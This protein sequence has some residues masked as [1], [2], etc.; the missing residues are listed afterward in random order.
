[1]SRRSLT[2][3]LALIAIPVALFACP[4]ALRPPVGSVGDDR[5][6]D[7]PPAGDAPA[8]DGPSDTAAIPDLPPVP[9]DRSLPAPGDLWPPSPDTYGPQPFGCQLASDCFG[10]KCCPTPWGVN[11][12]APSCDFE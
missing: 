3:G 7:G 1:M 4:G 12:C 9:P 6:L 2:L 8:N 10:E 5:P 11:L